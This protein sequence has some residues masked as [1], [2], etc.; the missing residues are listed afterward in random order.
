MPTKSLKYSTLNWLVISH[1]SKNITMDKTFEEQYRSCPIRNVIAHFGDKWSLVVLYSIGAS[2]TGV[3]RFSELKNLMTDCSQKML[4]ATLKNLEH[5]NLI[6]RKVYPVV[7]PKV[8]YSLTETGKSLMPA[9]KPLIDWSL[10][11][12]NEV[13]G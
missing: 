12:F 11:H 8:E 9:L 1:C 10:E 7:P 2:A 6:N 13:A 3:L 4:S 5:H